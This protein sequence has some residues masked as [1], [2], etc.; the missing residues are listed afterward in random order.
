[1]TCDLSTLSVPVR[2][3]L[4]GFAILTKAG[5]PP[6]LVVMGPGVD[7]VDE[8]PCVL[9][10]VRTPAGPVTKA[11]VPIEDPWAF[12]EELVAAL[13]VWNAASDDE[14]EALVDESDVRKEAGMLLLLF[15]PHKMLTT[16]RP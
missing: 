6:E 2:E 8:E 1:M 12:R 9:L 16:A 4:A 13:P 3:A 11:M 10:G 14:R 7:P 15:A 5:W